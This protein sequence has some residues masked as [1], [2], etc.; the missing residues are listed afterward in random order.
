MNFCNLPREKEHD[1]ERRYE[2][3]NRELRAML[4]IEG[5]KCHG[6]VRYVRCQLSKRFKECSVLLLVSSRCG[7]PRDLQELQINAFESEDNS[8]V[9]PKDPNSD[10]HYTC[11]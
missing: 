10:H 6:R 11:C 8:P 3:L 2:L 5:K 4:A 1:L 9:K 7:L